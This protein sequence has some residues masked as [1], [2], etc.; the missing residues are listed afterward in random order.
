MRNA[1]VAK[2]RTL[3]SK[4]YC[5]QTDSRI[6]LTSLLKSHCVFVLWP[7]LLLRHCNL[8]NIDDRV[9]AGP[10]NAETITLTLTYTW[11]PM[12]DRLQRRNNSHSAFINIS[13]L[14]TFQLNTLCSK[15]QIKI[16]VTS[17]KHY[18]P[19][20]HYAAYCC[21][22]HAR[23]AVN[24]VVVSFGHVVWPVDQSP[25]VRIFRSHFTFRIPHSALHSSI[26]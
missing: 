5:L 8:S 3:C 7:W 11:P 19:H 13:F 14:N 17:I 18:F 26:A 25:S 16:T 21:A 22:G 24:C 15:W 20:P 9:R 10:S 1:E 2:I 6:S 23:R 12:F 4:T